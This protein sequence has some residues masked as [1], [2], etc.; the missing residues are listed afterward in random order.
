[1]IPDE[2]SLQE[3]FV[4]FELIGRR[5]KQ[6][7][8]HSYLYYR[9]DTN[10]IDDST[11]DK[12]AKELCELKEKYPDIAAQTK[13]WYIGKQFDASGSGYFINS[14]P[15]ELVM[16]AELLVYGFRGRSDA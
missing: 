6:L 16:Q 1:V 7:I 12:W 2:L 4:L 8:V 3:E 10:K 14:Y 13:Y 11:F 5:I 15:P 9:L